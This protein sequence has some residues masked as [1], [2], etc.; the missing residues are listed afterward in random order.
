MIVNMQRRFAIYALV[1]MVALIFA[2]ELRD[3][4]AFLLSQSVDTNELRALD[5]AAYF[6]GCF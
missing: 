2:P 3:A 6:V 4:G 5:Q 1:G